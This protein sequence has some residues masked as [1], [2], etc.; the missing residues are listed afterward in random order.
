MLMVL[1]ASA[2]D[3]RGADKRCSFLFIFPSLEHNRCICRTPSF[4]YPWRN[5]RL[6]PRPFVFPISTRKSPHTPVSTIFR[7]SDPTPHPLFHPSFSCRFNQKES[8]NLSR[9][10]SLKR[11]LPASGLALTSRLLLLLGALESSGALD[12]LGAEVGTVALGEGAVDD[13]AVELRA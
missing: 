3:S 5:Q 12:G 7:P 9:L 6:S 10:S 2:S 4:S 11:S 1:V 8:R 13:G